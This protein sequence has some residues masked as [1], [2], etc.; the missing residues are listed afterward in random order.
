MTALPLRFGSN[1]WSYLDRTSL[2]YAFDNISAMTFNE[3]DKLPFEQTY[4]IPSIGIYLEGRTANPTMALS[5]SSVTYLFNLNRLNI[6]SHHQVINDN[7]NDSLD[8]SLVIEG[9]SNTDVQGNKILIFIPIKTV[10]VPG[11][12]QNSMNGL[13]TI[14]S[15]LSDNTSNVRTNSNTTK[16]VSDLEFNINELIPNEN[17]YIYQKADENLT[18][19][20]V[21]FFDNSNLFTSSIAKTY[22]DTKFR[23]NT[24]NIE[25]NGLQNTSFEVATSTFI[26]YKSGSK[27]TKKS[28][29]TTT[30]EDNIYIDCK[31]VDIPNEEKE[32][33]FQ[34]IEGYGDFLQVGFVYLFAIIFIS[35]LVYL[36]Y[37]IKT[38]FKTSADQE[39]TK[40]NDSLQEFSKYVNLSNHK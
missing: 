22:L 34:K 10:G 14:F 38:I 23:L 31:P 4:K 13:N 39:I 29:I 25:Y 21:V 35:I 36:I 40:I 26:L 1:S 9:Y 16:T 20:F 33:Y 32:F 2:S 27:P 12:N 7:E 37:N 8:Y 15:F 19:Y 28:S 3:N 6:S 5:F 24:Y 30:F 17:F 18:N 11:T